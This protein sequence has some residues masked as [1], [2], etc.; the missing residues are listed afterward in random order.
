[1]QVPKLLKP[2]VLSF[3]RSVNKLPPT[4]VPVRPLPNTKADDCFNIVGRQVEGGV[5]S[6][7]L[8][9][10]IWEWPK[11]MIEAEFHA[12]WRDPDGNL[13][14]LTPKKFTEIL[15]LPDPMKRYEGR[16][17][18]NV[19][20]AL[21]R[22]KDIDRFIALA[23]ELYLEM[24]RGD[25]ADFHGRITVTPAIHRIMREKSYLQAKLAEKYGPPFR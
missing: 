9:W 21:S 24:N 10:S 14:D 17:V 25:L 11:V 22:N 1:M 3:C 5:G 19:R 20:K 8:G 7:V 18:N 6:M 4:H 16:Q 13:F 23:D 15:F 2:Y 12:V